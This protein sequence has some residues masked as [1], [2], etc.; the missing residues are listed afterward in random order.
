M[1]QYFW[2][3]FLK[4]LFSFCIFASLGIIFIYFYV[5][6]FFFA[7]FSYDQNRVE[8]NRDGCLCCWKRTNW[9]PSK[10][11]QRS[12]LRMVFEVLANILVFLPSKIFVLLLTLGILAGGVLGVVRID[13]FFD[14]NSFITEGSYLRN[15]LMFKEK[16]FPNG[17]QT[18]TIY[19][20][21]VDYIAEMEKIQLLLSDLAEL[22]TA[23][24][25]NI[26]SDSLKFWA[27]DFLKFVSKK[28]GGAYYAFS[29]NRNY[30]N[31]S[32]QEDL[33]QFL[34]NPVEGR[35]YRSNFEFEG[36]VID[37]RR[38][39]PKVLLSSMS[40]QHQIFDHSADGIAAMN[41][42]FEA[43]ERQNFSGKVF[44]TSQAYSSYI[45]MEIITEELC[46]NMLMAL[47][48]VFVCTLILIADLATSF[49]V[50]IT[51]TLTV[52]NVAGY[53]YFWGLSI[54]TLF[55]IFM[56]ISIGLCVDYSAHIA[57]GF[58]IE[59]G[60]NNERMKKT[61]TKVGPAVFNGGMSTFLSFVQVDHLPHL[62]QDLLPRYALRLV[63]RLLFLP[64]LLS[65][66]SSKSTDNDLNLDTKPKV[67]KSARHKT[68]NFE[69]TSS[70]ETKSF[71]SFHF[72]NLQPFSLPGSLEALVYMG[73]ILKRK[74]LGVQESQGDT[75]ENLFVYLL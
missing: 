45:T 63:P 48:V 10:C 14:Y 19:F 25:N 13:T 43:I 42:V 66:I 35:R 18:A 54:D 62:L 15:F 39:A 70:V 33:S 71:T 31:A 40:F 4:F 61:L 41:Q 9:Q 47:A 72:M 53:A 8:T 38:P 2:H 28:R 52:V 44:A 34:N 1:L 29:F 60:S 50:L 21:D 36:G 56:T 26:A 27:R 7:W 30:T 5:I 11:S 74:S 22:S 17:G 20:A 46:R 37:P 23:K 16:H 68:S 67:I 58:T 55:A 75:M 49:I 24:R 65:L 3:N 59:E 51:V 69:E 57:H 12:L 73:E 64:V 32:F 6:T